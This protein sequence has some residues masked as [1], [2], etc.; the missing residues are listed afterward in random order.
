MPDIVVLAFDFGMKRIGIAVGSTV[1]RH[2]KPL[3]CLS[4]KD[5]VPDWSR[6]ETLI[7]EWGINRFVVG[8]PTHIDGRMQHTTNATTF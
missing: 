2:A 3:S 1:I 4:A 8:I 7:K 5:G 6:I